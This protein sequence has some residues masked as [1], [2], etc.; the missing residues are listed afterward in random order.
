[1]F[2]A[3]SVS[4]VLFLTA[5]ILW[6]FPIFTPPVFAQE[7]YFQEEF[8]AE[9]TANTLD[10]NKWIV[11]PNNPP[12]ITTIK[13][14]NG[15]VFLTTTRSLV[16]PYVLS[17]SNPFPDGDFTLEFGIQ[18]TSVPIRGSGLVFSVV[19][20]ANGVSEV[21]KDTSEVYFFGVWQGKNDGLDIT[22]NGYCAVGLSCTNPGTLVYETSSPNTI[23]QKIVLKRIGA[24]YEVYVNGAKVFTSPPSQVKPDAIWFGNPTNQG[25]PDTWTSFRIDYIR[26][27]QNFPA[28]FLDLPWDY[29]ANGKSFEQQV[30]DPNAWFDHAFPLQNEPCCVKQIIKYTGEPTTDFY[31]SHSGY[32]YA[33]QNGV[34]LYTPVLA[35][36][37]GIATFKSKENSSGAGHIIR[38]DHGNGYQ[39]WYEHL[40]PIGL[41]VS[42]EGESVQVVKG[43]QIGRVGMTGNTTGPHIHFS[44][45]KDANNNGDFNDD[46]PY[47]LV[48]PLGWEG[49]NPDPWE[50]WTSNERFG[51]KSYQLFTAL[52]PPKSANIPPIGGSLESGKAEIN[53]PAGAADS[54]FSMIFKNGPFESATDFVK[55]IVP[56]FFLNAFNNQGQ[57]MNQFNQPVEIIYDY[58]EA[59]LNN[60]DEDTV[61]LYYFNEETSNWE[62]LQS[63]LDKN[64]KTVTTQTTHFTQFAIMGEIKDLINPETE[65][66]IT[67]DKGQDNWYR[68]NVIVEL[69]GKDNTNGLGVYYTLYTLDGNNWN[70]Y[71]FPLK[72]EEEGMYEITYLSI[73]EADNREERK[74]LN[75]KIDKTLPIVTIS[76]EREPDNSGWYNR[77]V[78]FSLSGEDQDSG[79][80]FCDP[81]ILYSSPDSDS[82]FISGSCTDFAGN[83]G[84]NAT[85][86]KYDSTIP[87]LNIDVRPKTLWPPDGSMVDV[88]LTGD[89]SELLNKKITVEDEYGLVQPKIVDFNQVFQLE[90]RRD[91]SDKDGRVYI[92]K[93]EAED[94][95]GNKSEGHVQVIVPH[96]KGKRE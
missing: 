30:F 83:I 19:A 13:E 46:Y 45:F 11:Y 54:A 95:A 5:V 6:L 48:D 27:T 86:I 66:R 87:P 38:I 73:D 4:T 59:D 47:G 88:V 55:S 29:D 78:L 85:V 9:R 40:D 61:K 91:G 26:I 69:L 64:N 31:R 53:V 50:S 32:D 72:F 84:T 68:S 25:V 18:F 77:P 42:T 22:Y 51:S 96:D 1:M 67:G 63:V 57:E 24:V 81:P 39:T 82:A 60:I 34:Q 92:I 15:Y 17:K 79:I 49:N 52:A 41:V 65:V 37:S 33:L 36:A 93:V 20:P 7:F 2:R 75:F 28:P 74:T 44:V 16:F 23:N 76:A 10:T 70:P 80:L 3:L 58:S 62:P 56:S 43:Q 89:S 8:N 90:A 12:G 14:G 35:A 21:E 94:L 71:S